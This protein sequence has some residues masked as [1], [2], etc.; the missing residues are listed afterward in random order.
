LQFLMDSW[1]QIYK[2]S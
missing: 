2:T 1:G